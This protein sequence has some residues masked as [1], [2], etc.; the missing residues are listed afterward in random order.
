MTKFYPKVSIIIPVYNGSNYLREAIDSA[1]AQTY[2]NIEIIVINDGSNDKG[3]TEK[4]AKSYGNRVKYYKKKN[5]GVATALNLGIRKMTGEYFSWL[6]HDDLYYNDKI[7]KQIEFLSKRKD[8]K[9]FLYSNYSIL[10]NG[11][12]SP[13]V[14]NHE[15][16]VRK[17]KYSLLRGCVNGITLLIPK[18]IFDEMGEFDASLR[19][20]QDYEYWGRI[21]TKYS[22]VHMEDVLSITRLHPEQDSNVS[23]RVVEEGDKLWID[24]IKKMPDKEKIKYENTLYNFYFEMVK[25]LE[26]T[27]Y[28]G[29]LGY[30]KTILSNLEADYSGRRLTQKVSVVIPFYNRCE[31]TIKAV[32]SVLRQSYDNI[33]VLL[34]NDGSTEDITKIQNLV[35]VHENVRLID[36]EKNSGPAFARNIGIEEST[37]EYIAFLDSDDEFVENKIK[38]Q[39]TKMVSHNPVISYT[40]YIRRD[41]QKETIMRDSQLTGLV[42]PKIISGASIA[43]P[44]VVVSRKF[45]LDNDI[46]FREDIRLGEDS[47]FWLEVAKYS[48]ILLV[49]EPLTIVNVD[50]NS[51]AYN[52][53]KSIAG[54]K[55]ILVYL[56][57]DDYYSKFNYDIS[58]VCDNFH[59]I[60]QEVLMKRN[61]SSTG[62][63]VAESS[64]FSTLKVKVRQPYRTAKRLYRTGPKGLARAVSRRVVKK[65]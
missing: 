29:T 2:K 5:G 65:R 40:T 7:E 34:V 42:V 21:Q 1:L 33:E 58:L 17:R 27:P 47:C 13:V 15:M 50:T 48:E 30:C 39:L 55:N 49:D 53:E 46:R 11:V 41:D 51:A 57:T 45:L 12:I 25:F 54:I 24:M 37:G 60:N 38:L 43:T 32:E 61:R 62:N 4:I 20:T 14:H 36:V 10:R 35:R 64:R 56:L 26:T 3:A 44:T 23:P 28:T 52:E 8:R 63:I 18:S 9:V 16:L 22:F 59:K 19:C 6:S 31:T